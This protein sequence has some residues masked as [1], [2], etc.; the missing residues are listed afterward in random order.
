MA[1]LTKS[2]VFLLNEVDSMPDK[3]VDFSA[4]RRAP[5]GLL[6]T[7]FARVIDRM[8]RKNLLARDYGN[9]T[10]TF[11]GMCALRDAGW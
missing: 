1:N 8:V 5:H 9:V 11:S 10:I 7:G 4:L 3:V 6:P 2:E